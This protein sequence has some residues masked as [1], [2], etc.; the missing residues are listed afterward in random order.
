[1]R[2]SALIQ[3]AQTDLFGTREIKYDWLNSNDFLAANY[4]R[5]V[6]ESPHYF[7]THREIDKI[8][9][10]LT[11]M[12]VDEIFPVNSVGIV[13]ARDKLT[14]RWT[15]NE[16]WNTVSQ[17]SKMDPEIARDA[18]QLGVDVRDW[19][20]S[21]AQEDLKKSGLHRKNIVPILAQPFD[22]RFTY[23]TGNS[24]GFHCM[25]RNEVMQH[26]LKV[27]NNLGLAVSKRVEGNKKWEHAFVTDKIMT[28]HA[29]SNKE[30]NFLFP[31]Y[32]YKEKSARKSVLQTMILFEPEVDY[33]TIVR[34]PNIEKGFYEKLTRIYK[35]KPEPEEIFHYIYAVLYSN[36]YRLKYSEFLKSDLPRIPFT[37]DYRLFIKMANL[38]N[39][40]VDLHLM[41]SKLLETPVSKYHG[42]SA[43]DQ[44]E[45]VVYDETEQTLHINGEKYFD[46]ISNEVWNYQIG[47]YPV[48]KKYLKDRKGLRLNDSK[49]FGK[50]VT[51]LAETIA[52]Q[53]EIDG[54]YTEIDQSTFIV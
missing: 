20:V 28:H 19:K 32:L 37:E 48:L 53:K 16:V 1:M 7:F 34:I 27:D 44:I 8:R 24:R 45:R 30:V 15:E 41:K 13:T 35:T 29:V 49:F 36:L 46:T 26:L 25:P 6:P 47:G 17:F 5:I 21:L 52:I 14:I 11:W 9:N 4:R 10:Y 33:S 22:N 18:Y 40:L 42:D 39:Q 2:R 54:I 51:A 31:L 3:C 12:P 50:I 23:Y 43:N 38:G